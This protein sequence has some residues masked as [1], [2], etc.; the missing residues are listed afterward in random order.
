MKI[1]LKA[2]SLFI[3]LFFILSKGESQVRLELESGMTVSNFKIKNLDIISQPDNYIG[4]YFGVNGKYELTDRLGIYVAAQ[5]SQEGSKEQSSSSRSYKLRLNPAIE[6]KILRSLGI[7]AG[8]SYS[9]R[10]RGEISIEDRGWE[11]AISLTNVFDNDFNALLGL[12]YSIQKFQL[13]V[14]YFHGIK[15]FYRDFMFTDRNG[16]PFE[17]AK[18]FNRCLQ[19]GLGYT[20]I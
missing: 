18:G 6:Y 12:N 8:V 4:Y 11:K 5:I 19:I 2:F 20:L 3:F 10:L 17:N 15:N 16:E 1:I 13:K 14:N 7:R 9:R